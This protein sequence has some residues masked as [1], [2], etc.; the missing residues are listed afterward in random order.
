MNYFLALQVCE[1]ITKDLFNNFIMHEAGFPEH[2]LK[3]DK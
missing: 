1:H 3:L 2:N